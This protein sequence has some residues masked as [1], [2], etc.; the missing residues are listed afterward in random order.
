MAD[1]PSSASTQEVYL[2]VSEYDGTFRQASELRYRYYERPAITMLSPP[3]GFAALATQVQ[4]VGSG[5]VN[6]A[7]IQVR[8]LDAFGADGGAP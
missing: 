3:D 5:F 4:L 6:F 1:L 8:A 2:Q 7:D